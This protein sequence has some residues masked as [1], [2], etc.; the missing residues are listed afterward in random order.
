MT[1]NETLIGNKIA[2]SSDYFPFSKNIKHHAARSSEVADAGA[3]TSPGILS[4]AGSQICSEREASVV[5]LGL[6]RT[7][8]KPFHFMINSSIN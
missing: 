1:L 3:M 2:N 7:M 8:S 6:D 4:S 5:N